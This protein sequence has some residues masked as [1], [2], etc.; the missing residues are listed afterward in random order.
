[1]EKSEMKIHPIGARAVSWMKAFRMQPFCMKT[2][3]IDGSITVLVTDAPKAI[4][5][6]VVLE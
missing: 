1:M 2:P 6:R 3:H 5:W 4:S